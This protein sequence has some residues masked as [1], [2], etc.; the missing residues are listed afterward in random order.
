MQFNVQMFFRIIFSAY[1]KAL[2][3]TKEQIT[4]FEG[5]G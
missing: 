3:K 5:V 4:S 2:W 1:N